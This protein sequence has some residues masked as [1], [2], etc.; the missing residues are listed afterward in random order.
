MTAGAPESSLRQNKDWRRLF[1]G[2]SVSI[3]GDMVFLVT[4]S[5]WIAT[6]LA[7][8]QSWAPAAVSGALIAAAVPALIVGPFAGVWVDRW[9]R[10]RI[11]LTSDA[12][13]FILIACLLVLPAVRHT[14][15]VGAQLALLYLVL[16][17]TSGFAE[18]FDPSRLAFIGAIV[19]S[20]DQPKASGQLEATA[21]FAQIIGPPIAAP[22]LFTLGVQWALILNAASFGVSYLCVRAIR[23]QPAADSV[24][25]ERQSF[26]A[27]F[28]I[29]IRFFVNSKILVTL[30]VGIVIAMLGVG[31]VNALAVFFIP[32]NLHVSASWLGTISAAVGAGGVIGAIGGGMVA[33]RVKPGRLFWIGLLAG[34]VMLIV[35]SR[36]T[37]LV[38]AIISCVVLGMAI[39]SL[40]AVIGPMMLN[41]TPAHLVGRVSAVISPVQQISSVGSMAVA[42]VLASTALRGMHVVIGGITFSSYDTIFGVAGLALVVAGLASIRPMRSALTPEDPDAV[43]SD[44]DGQPTGA[45]PVV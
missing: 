14:I 2:Q 42:G 18:F 38:P 17:V 7:A 40:N 9:D 41:A 8:G 15:P 22:L 10:R 33:N 1:V 34:G 23:P 4:I 24:P 13:R 31:A 30:G 36:C 12:A 45:M 29:G 43:D 25:P 16:A 21:A 3:V 26:T 5:L 20:E 39:G 35:L 11:M 27:E 37:A 32:H 6:K 44:A 19:P 28:A